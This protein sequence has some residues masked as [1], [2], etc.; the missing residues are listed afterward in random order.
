MITFKRSWLMA[1]MALA[2]TSSAHAD[3]LEEV[4]K[5]TL[6]TNP[7]VL[8]KMNTRLSVDQEVRQAKSGYYPSIDL[9][10]G[11]GR[12]NTDNAFT[13]A[14]GYD[15][16]S[17][18][19]QETGVALRQSLYA[20]GET[21]HEVERQTQR[22]NSRA[23]TMHATAEQIA[24]RTTEV[25]LEVLRRQ[26]LVKLA[27][28]NLKSHEKT[29]DQVSSRSISGI[30]R[31]ADVD[32]ARSRLLLAKSN[33]MAEESNLR[34]AEINY[35][36]V[37]NA[38]PNKLSIPAAPVDKVPGSL[39]GA[40]K[41]AVGNHPTLKAA[42]ADIEAAEEQHGTAKSPY[43]PKLDLE[44]GAA[45]NDNISGLAGENNNLYAMLRMRYNLYAGGKD[46]AR[47]GQAFYQIYEAKE[48]HNRTC[49]QVVEGMRLSWNAF[50]TTDA[51]VLYLKQ[52]VESSINARASYRSQFTL[53][54]RSLL[55]LLD[56]ENEVFSASKALTHGEFD[57]LFSS[58]RV[59]AGEGALLSTLALALPPE[60]KPLTTNSRE[61]NCASE[62]P[63][64]QV[65]HATPLA[66]EQKVVV[67]QVPSAPVVI[68]KTMPP[69][70]NERFTLQAGALFDTDKA[71]LKPEGKT[72]LDFL[73]VKLR[74]IKQI[75]GLEVIGHTDSRGSDKHNKDL[76]LRRAKSVVEHLIMRGISGDLLSVKGMGE[77]I[78][79]ATNKTEEGRAKNRRVEVNIKV[80][81]Q[82]ESEA[83]AK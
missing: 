13:R 5:Q 15:G 43:F 71:V 29:Y 34:E 69:V 81:R 67:L 66:P 56:S 4:V 48:I 79:V 57:R 23:Y 83:E 47:R 24:L 19:R 58:Y 33:L 17:L 16:R 80:T 36:R 76:S 28:D 55:D 75:Q 40:V 70:T 39:S 3:T 60:A 10:A 63:E 38:A 45:R 6:S 49:R 72:E 32:Q 31:G 27:Q 9:N 68:E 12:E 1:M 52:R 14:A 26:E 30:G 25:Y 46:Q 78:P 51:Q 2:S 21:R 50:K 62:F 61:V 53:G 22:T 77:D 44:L 8:E 37:V 11:T 74:N 73:Y 59:M 41:Q 65:P 64:Q 42:A 7:D 20:G 18:T 82:L 35:F 54:Q